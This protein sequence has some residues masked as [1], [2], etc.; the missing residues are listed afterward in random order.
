MCTSVLYDAFNVLSVFHVAQSKGQPLALC[1]TSMEAKMLG[2]QVA[3]AND[4]GI[5]ITSSHGLSLLWSTLTRVIFALLSSPLAYLPEA[6]DLPGISLDFAKIISPSNSQLPAMLSE[7]LSISHKSRHP[8]L[9][10]AKRPVSTVCRN[11]AIGNPDVDELLH[12][13]E[14][15]L[16]N[17]PK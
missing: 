9:G 5:I 13:L 3:V 14:V 7:H 11:R 6:L 4:R 17:Q 1:G 15:S 2:G 10:D 8:S 12:G 16:A